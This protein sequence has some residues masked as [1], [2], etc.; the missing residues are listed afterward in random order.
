[1]T[2]VNELTLILWTDDKPPI[3][4]NRYISCKAERIN[5]TDQGNEREV[6]FFGLP[7]M[8]FDLFE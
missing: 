6:Y 4:F 5:V 8:S 7:A 3:N 2:L 1:M